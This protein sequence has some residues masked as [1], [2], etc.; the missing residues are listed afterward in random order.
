MEYLLKTHLNI[1]QYIVLAFILL[2]FCL[3]LSLIVNL[4][5][6]C[7]GL[8][9]SGK[10]DIKI[11]Y[12]L[13]NPFLLIKDTSKTITITTEIFFAL[14]SFIVFAHYFNGFKAVLLPLDS[15]NLFNFSYIFNF[16]TAIAW[17]ILAIP[18]AVFI[19]GFLLVITPVCALIGLFFGY[20]LPQVI[21][22]LLVSIFTI[23]T[24]SFLLISIQKVLKRMVKVN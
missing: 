19:R 24:I 8:D 14:I 17:S 7:V 3:G 10:K 18:A 9:S 23:S 4:I 16:M 11:Y 5:L 22:F 20:I 21:G 1:W 13:F 12:I 6:Y 2:G 15:T